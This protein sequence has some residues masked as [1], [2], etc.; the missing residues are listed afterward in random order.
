MTVSLKKK[1]Y[2]HV[3]P[4]TVSSVNAGRELHD[5]L[6]VFPLSDLLVVLGHHLLTQLFIATSR[7]CAQLFLLRLKHIPVS[8]SIILVT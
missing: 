7:H 2:L 8:F 5:P 3:K 4:A 6:G 1:I